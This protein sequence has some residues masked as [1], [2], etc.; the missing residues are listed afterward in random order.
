MRTLWLALSTITVAACALAFIR[1]DAPKGNG[2]KGDPVALVKRGDYLVNEVARC[3]ECHT[4]RDARGRLDKA[5]NLQGAPVPF[6]PKQR[7]QE[8]EDKAPDI[9]M[10]G[11]AGHWSEEKLIRYLMNG[12]EADAPMPA[13]HLTH[14]DATA[15]A[16]YL[17]SLPGKPAK[18]K[19]RQPEKEK[20]RAK[21][22]D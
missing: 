22:D 5:R 6:T 20:K 12:E 11:K 19:D 7:G 9:T 18:G 1:A 14:D 3:G 2:A 8:W 17:R 21:V 10:S 4:P 13:Y 16:A 15:V